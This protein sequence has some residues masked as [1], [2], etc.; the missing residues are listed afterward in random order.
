MAKGLVY[1]L[2]FAHSPYKHARHYL[3]A[4]GL[5]IEDRVAAH[6]GVALHEGDRSYGRPAKLIAALLAAGG[7]FVVA[8]V[9]ETDTRAEAFELEKRLKKQG[10]RARLCSI[11]SPGNVRGTGTGNWPRTRP[12]GETAPP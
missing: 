3:G 5:S 8:D 12:E 4:T 10:S 7:D 2:C 6:R 1:L 9:W 11:C